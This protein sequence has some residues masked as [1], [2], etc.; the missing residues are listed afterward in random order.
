MGLYQGQFLAHVPLNSFPLNRV[1]YTQ[2]PQA[3]CA[4]PATRNDGQFRAALLRVSFVSVMSRGVSIS[5]S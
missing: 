2:F 3:H 1:I 4:K 5:A